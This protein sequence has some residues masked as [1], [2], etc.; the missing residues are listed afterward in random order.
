M[1]KPAPPGL[2]P[3]AVDLNQ[4]VFVL[5]DALDFVGVDDLRHGK[6]VAYMSLECAAAGL[7]LDDPARARLCQ[8]GLIHDIGVSSTRVHRHLVNELEWSDAQDHCQVGA[9]LLEGFAPLAH[10]AGIIRYHHTHWRAMGDSGLPYQDALLANLIFLTDRV[11]ALRA[12]QLEQ[13]NSHPE[14][15]VRSTISR[16]A[17]DFFAPQLVEAFLGVSS[18]AGFWIGLE[19]GNLDAYFASHLPRCQARRLDQSE[20]RGL[21]QLFAHVVDAKSH[22]T[23]RHSEGVARLAA[24]LAQ[25]RGIEGERLALLE[26]AALLHDLGKLR[27]PD[28]ILEKPASL[29]VSEWHVMQRHSLD[30]HNI[31]ERI[32][33][34]KEVAEWAGLHHETP[35]G[36]GYP[37]GYRDAQVPLEARIIS[38]ADVFQALAQERPYRKPLAP[39]AILTELRRQAAL[40]HLDRE[41]VTMVSGDLYACWRAAVGA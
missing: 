25:R 41:V 26:I 27:V 16:F 10:M 11:D 40:G 1:E 13:G 21:A 33:G 5:S 9:E 20:A 7:G 28:E 38:V 6:R 15:V 36:D 8:A 12:Q 31:L 18:G 23:F 35:R 17:G 29:D 14:A 2:P 34:L 19:R 39:E 4:A 32:D 22:Y 30:S 24:L 3:L 37:F